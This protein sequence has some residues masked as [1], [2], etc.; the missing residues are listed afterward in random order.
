M[1]KKNVGIKR[2]LAEGEMKKMT[3]C[4]Q[5]VVHNSYLSH[6]RLIV[7]WPAGVGTT[8]SMRDGAAPTGE[9]AAPSKRERFDPSARVKESQGNLVR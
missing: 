1:G 7:A 9:C 6:E 5:F 8:T 2:V 3:N 4:A